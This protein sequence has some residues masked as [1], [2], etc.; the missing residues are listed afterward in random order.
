MGASAQ[1]GGSI[2]IDG[3]ELRDIDPDS[4]YDL[5]SLIG[6]NVFLFDDTVANNIP[7][8]GSSPP[9]RW[10]A[11]CSAA[12]WRP[13]RPSA[14]W[15][16]PA[17]KTA[18]GFRAESGSGYPSPGACCGGTPVLLL[19]EA[20]A[21][22]DNQTAFAVTQAVLDLDGLT[23]LVVTPPPGRRPAAPVRR[24]HCAAGRRRLRARAI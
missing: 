9:M 11:R 6:Q 20:T 18:A 1:Y 7:C 16:P 14:G 22:L 24:D 12:A 19:D 17:V 13:W 15:T 23:R 4:L 3:Q 10:S 8:S 21:A 5:C 2:A